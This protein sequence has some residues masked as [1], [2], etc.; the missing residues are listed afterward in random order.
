MYCSSVVYWHKKSSSQIIFTLYVWNTLIFYFFIC[1]SITV[2]LCLNE[3][4]LSSHNYKSIVSLIGYLFKNYL[5]FWPDMEKIQFYCM[6]KL[7]T[8]YITLP[9]VATLIQVFVVIILWHTSYCKTHQ[10]TRIPDQQMRPFTS[11]SYE[12]HEFLS[13]G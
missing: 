4:D 10:T 3:S 9:L 2:G 1:L 5:L 8:I 6:Q 11:S 7:H 13:A 12:N